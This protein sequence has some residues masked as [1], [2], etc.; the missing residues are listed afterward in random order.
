MNRF[1]YLD[2]L[3]EYFNDSKLL[4]EIV[5]AMS[6]TEAKEIFDYIC[7][8]W[9]IEIKEKGGINNGTSLKNMM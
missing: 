9:S 8:M 1:E 5:H 6:D 3:R 7:R 2:K 4:E